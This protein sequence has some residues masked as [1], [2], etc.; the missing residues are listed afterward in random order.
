[1]SL[2]TMR[3]SF[4]HS[5]KWIMGV[6]TVAML[7]TA[8]A[9]LGSNFGPN[10]HAPQAVAQT[11]DSVIAT[12]N[13]EPITRQEY[14]NTYGQEKQQQQMFQQTQFSVLNDGAVHNQ[15]LQQVIREQ[16][17]II[18]AQNSG[19]AVSDADIAKVRAPL[20]TSLRTQLGLPANASTDDINTALSKVSTQT[21]DDLFPDSAMRDEALLQK[22]QDRLKAASAPTDAQMA[23]YYKSVH[24]RHILIANK[25]RPDA[26]AQNQAQQ[27]IAKIKAGG[28]FAGLAKEYSDDP[29]SKNKGGDDGFITQQT[30]YVPE[31]LNA[32]MQLQAGETTPQPIKSPQYG[33][34]IIQAV[35]VKENYPADYQKNKAKYQQQVSQANQSKVS[36][37]A[38]AQVAATAKIVIKDPMLRAFWTMGE[39]PAP[40]QTAA[41]QQ[42]SAVS[43]LNQAA[44][45]T[46]DY[47]EKALIYATLA[48]LA[49]QQKDT[50]GELADLNNALASTEDSQLR[51]MLGTA[52]RQAGNVPAALAQYSQASNNSYGDTS[53]H[54]Q[55]QQIYK[56]MHQ[57]ALEQKEAALL[58]QTAQAQ[59]QLGGAS[60]LGA[61]ITA[62]IAHGPQVA[63]KPTGQSSS[64]KK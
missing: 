64:A 63:L 23:D 50:K 12:V 48:I 22:Y 5:A 46:K 31:F 59:P 14:L 9:G 29:G 41:T 11:G 4:H 39:P 20:L 53:V 28:D 21:V 54:L 43:D 15:A 2:N 17:A 26:Q 19:I 58:K 52:Y 62:Q 3:N 57:P 36:E 61:P 1:M 16:E 51:M 60:A 33:Y 56:S 24:T 7:V 10:R 25:T 30:Q 38:V 32:A 44:A 47:S 8:W 45:T 34:F 49:Q 55:L 6:V 18:V 27:I 40:G 37:A 35:A 13:G 42:A